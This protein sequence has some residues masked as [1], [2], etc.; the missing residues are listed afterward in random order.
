[1]RAIGDTPRS[2]AGSKPRMHIEP[3]HLLFEIGSNSD[4]SRRRGRV[5]PPEVVGLPFTVRIVRTEEHLTKAVEIRA[6]TYGRHHP[7]M[8]EQLSNPEA[9]DRSP[10][11]LVLLAESK[12]DANALGTLRIETNTLTSLPVESLLPAASMYTGRTIAFVTRLGVR[13]GPGAQLV[14][15]TLFKA[16]HRYC[17]ACQI[18]W[19]IVTARPPMDRQYLKL[20]F[21]DVYD[22]DTLIPVPWSQNIPM[23]L[24]ALN[25]IS[26]EREWR[27]TNHPLYK[28]M[29]SDYC[30]D[31]QI[32]S[33]VSG[34]WGRPRAR[35]A[36]PP[37]EAILAEIFGVSVV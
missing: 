26:C 11:S 16:L 5:P 29:F 10:F 28:Y 17:L 21:I 1:L 13:N 30:P 2:E 35:S 23:R 34:I 4:P 24:L 36:S 37:S 27:A 12:T 32:F 15:L 19:L 33:S 20:G 3:P 7:E 18:D 6:E 31:I 14:K 22:A 9:A 8:A 25:T